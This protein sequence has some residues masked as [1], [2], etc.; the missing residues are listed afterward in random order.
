MTLVLLTGTTFLFSTDRTGWLS[1]KN[2]VDEDRAFDCEARNV[3][4]LVTLEE[5]VDDK[6][7]GLDKI[8]DAKRY[9]SLK[10]LLQCLKT[11]YWQN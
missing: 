3:N 1:Q 6:M 11:I 10:L 5:T 8:I 9:S 2:F 7:C 4:A